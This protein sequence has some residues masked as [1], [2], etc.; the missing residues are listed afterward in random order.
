MASLLEQLFGFGINRKAS[1]KETESFSID[2]NLT[3]DGVVLQDQTGATGGL[4]ALS[5]EAAQIPAAEIERVQTFREMALSSEVDEA[6]QEIRNEVFIFDVPGERA[7]ELAFTEEDGAPAESIQKR[8]IDEFKNIY[9]LIDFHNKGSQYF[10]D[11]YVDS[12]IFFHKIIDAQHPRAGIQKVVQVDPLKIRKI[13]LMPR[14]NSNG[15]FDLSKIKELYVYSNRFAPNFNFS[16]VTDIYF[17]TNINGLQINPDAI[18]Y[19]DSGLFDRAIGQYTGYLQKAILPF[20]N[21]RMMEN[22]MLVFRVVRAPQRR[23]IYIDVSTMQKSK[24]E[25]YMKDMMAR[26]KNKMVYDSKTGTLSDRRNIQSMMEDYWLPRRD[27][28]K[29]T[30]IQTLEG[31]DSAHTLEEVEYYRDKLWRS[32][33]V[34]K[35]RF[36]DP[37]GTFSF[38]RGTEIQRDEYRFKKFIDRLRQ[39]FMRVFDDL[40]RTQLILKNVIKEDEWPEIRKYIFWN[41]AEDNAF[42]EYKESE[43]INNRVTM[44]GSIEPYVGKYFSREWVR[45][46]ILRQSDQEIEQEDE[47]M[48]NEPPLDDLDPN[49]P[50]GF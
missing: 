5:F 45:R 23:A 24:A 42:V 38:G 12:K 30:E 16:G 21:L 8:I 4:T 28:G 36:A 20:N 48:K 37:A 6:L 44:L 17:G 34:P 2:K 32:L 18:T 14:P 46:K 22:A 40:L 26:F 41:Y 10:D 47:R 50:K 43:L 19:V 3:A 31:Q 11:W 13:R 39:S 25:Q 35:S 33:N 29:G 7:F 27:G 9:T 1:E 49:E 15:I